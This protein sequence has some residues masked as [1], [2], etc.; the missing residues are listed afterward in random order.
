M[1]HSDR[2]IP[3]GINAIRGLKFE[4][5]DDSVRYKLQRTG[6]EGDV[7]SMSSRIYSVWDYDGSLSQ[8]PG[9]AAILGSNKDFWKVSDSVYTQWNAWR[10][11]WTTARHIA[12]FEPVFPG[13]T[14][15][16]EVV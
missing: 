6:L 7:S 16:E 3:Q 2:Y 9:S 1:E 10:T 4:D 5:C 8:T 13:L 11:P 12:Y 15:W 14:G